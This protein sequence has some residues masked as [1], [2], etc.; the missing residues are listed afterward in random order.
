MFFN[1]RRRIRDLVLDV[2]FIAWMVSFLATGRVLP[3]PITDL[4]HPQ[5][6]VAAVSDQPSIPSGPDDAGIVEPEI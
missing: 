3:Q 6:H 2:L 4:L 5:P 1:P